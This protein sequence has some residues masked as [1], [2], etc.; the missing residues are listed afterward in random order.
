MNSYDFRGTVNWNHTFDNS[1]IVNLFGGME[2]SDIS[3]NKN[4]FN[5]WGMQY[6]RVKYLSILISSSKEH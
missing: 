6:T 4:F 1:H 5:G 3:R 2:V